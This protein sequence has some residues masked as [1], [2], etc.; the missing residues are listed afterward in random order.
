MKWSS[1]TEYEYRTCPTEKLVETGGTA[2][3]VVGDL[4]SCGSLKSQLNWIC[5]VITQGIESGRQK[6]TNRKLQIEWNKQGS[7]KV[8]TLFPQ[9]T[10]KEMAVNDTGLSV[11]HDNPL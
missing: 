2:G 9:S 6:A 5:H 4:K 1:T 11:Y 10:M 7:I 8:M 3:I